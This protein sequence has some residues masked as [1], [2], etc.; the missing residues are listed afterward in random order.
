[1]KKV[2]IILLI[3]FAVN[4]FSEEI[5]I[6]ENIKVNFQY[7]KGFLKFFHHTIQIGE[8]GTDFDYIEKGGQELL[9]PFERFSA[10]LFLFKKNKI[11]FLFQPLTIN[12]T[13]RFYEDVTIDDVTFLSDTIVDIKYGFP[14]Y[15]ITY[16]YQFNVLPFLEIGAG[17]ALQLRNASITFSSVNGESFTSSQNL[18]PV[19]ALHLNVL[20]PFSI[21]YFYF[22][23]TGLYA[24][25]SFINGASFE[26]EG[27]ILD[28]SLRVGVDLHKNISSYLNIRFIGGSAKGTSEYT[29]EKWSES[30]E[31]YTSNYIAL[32]SLSLGIELKL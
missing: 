19:P 31:R 4:A 8:S 26:F 27:S 21:F 22:E 25:S 11:T 1:M 29:N 18:G 24:S 28:T 16:S 14:F 15:R 5:S 30:R 7:E 9:F 20:C 32:G 12:T 2:I 6:N 10:D 13:T 17:L 23:A 3:V